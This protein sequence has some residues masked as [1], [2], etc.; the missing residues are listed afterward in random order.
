MEIFHAHPWQALLGHPVLILF[1]APAQ[2]PSFC[3]APNVS[4]YTLLNLSCVLH[5]KRNKQVA[6]QSFVF[7][8]MRKLNK[9][10]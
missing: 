4:G 1:S 9:V 5:E 7:L 10:R 6:V 3:S 2:T 8:Q